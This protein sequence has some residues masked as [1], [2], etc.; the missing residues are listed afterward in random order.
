MVIGA[1]MALAVLSAIAIHVLVSSSGK[2]HGTQSVGF[3]S[4]ESVLR[5]RSAVRRCAT[6]VLPILM[7]GA[8][9][10]VCFVA[11]GV[12]FFWKGASGAFAGGADDAL[13]AVIPT[14]PAVWVPLLLCAATA[15]AVLF[16]LRAPGRRAAVLVVLLLAD[17][18]FITRFVDAPP[19][20]AAPPDPD[21]SAAAEWLRANGPQDGSYRVWGLGEDY[22]DRPD[23]LLLPKTCQAM[24]FSTIAGYGPF[25]SPVHA[26]L[27]GFRIFGTNRDWETL[28]RRNYLLSL[29]N[30][31]YV[32]AAED[33]FRDLIESVRV[34]ASPP[35]PDGADVLPDDW[36]LDAAEAHDG[37]IRLRASWFTA[38]ASAQQPVRLRPG[39]TYRISLDARGPHGGAANSLRAEVFQ[40]FPDYRWH[41]RDEWGLTVYPE[42]LGDDW[43]HFE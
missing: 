13:R 11:F 27:L 5:L 42:Q 22:H 39:V 1:D 32:V 26:H 9:V 43:R 12:L 10:V 40:K 23:E 14:N 29:Y 18:F 41:S 25:Q 19:S 34:P 15:G 38:G 3:S 21:A 37:V 2:A 6:R 31:R 30:V 17:L 4:E 8:L 28:I 36:V 24:G 7:G 35:A 33:R 20:G 16:W